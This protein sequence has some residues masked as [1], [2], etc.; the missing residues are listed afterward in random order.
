[1][2]P[3]RRK[4]NPGRLATPAPADVMRQSGSPLDAGL[5]RTMEDRFGHDFG[6]VRIHADQHAAASAND[7]DAAA[8]ST[9]KDIVF[10]A[11]R[12]APDTPHG[13]RLLAH[14]LAHVV[15]RGNAAADRPI[16]S[17]RSSDVPTLEADARQAA[18]A[19]AGGGRADVHESAPETSLMRQ[20]ATGNAGTGTTPTTT[21]TPAPS[22]PAHERHEN[23]GR[24]HHRVDAELDRPIGMLTVQMKVKFEPRNTPQPWPSTARFERFK[25]DFVRTV[26][27]R[28]SFKHFLMPQ[29]E[30]PGEPPKVS[31]RVQVLSVTSGEHRTVTVGYA[32]EAQRSNVSELDVLDTELRSDKPQVPAEHEFGHMLGLPH[33]H[34]ARNDDEC[35]GVEREEKADLMGQGSFV[36]PHDYEPFTE[37]MPSFTSTTCQYRVQQAS[38][39]PTSRAPDIGAGIGGVLGALAG[40]AAGLAIGAAVGGPIG[41]AIGGLIGLIGG[42]IGGFFAGRALATPE[43]PS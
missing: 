30:C 43:V 5:R 1:M 42:G 11:G 29:T 31:V 32:T 34:C 3:V 20:E 24:A 4:V 17:A 13:E 22:R 14:E 27:A 6:D 38:S 41:A 35:Y 16:S 37:L 21:P 15:Q 12:F 39:I 9:G 8:Y 7:L 23:I 26:A 25:T 36:S 10:G 40:G 19:V 28:W 33:V 18:T 2:P